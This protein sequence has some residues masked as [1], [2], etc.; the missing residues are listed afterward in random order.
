MIAYSNLLCQANES[1][2]QFTVS[3]KWPFTAIY[4]V[5]QIIVNSIYCAKQVTVYS[6]LLCQANYRLQQFT[7]YSNL[8]CQANYRLQ[9]FTV[10]RKLPFTE[11]Y[12]VQQYFNYVVAVSF[13]GGENLRPA[14]HRN[15]IYH[16]KL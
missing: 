11:I 14:S 13:I 4:R 3:S 10:S 12:C 7:V 2:Q 5:K 9:Q 15:K 1:L 8:L 16:I 6:N